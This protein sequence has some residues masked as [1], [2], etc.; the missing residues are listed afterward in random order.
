M[1]ENK[2]NQE[3]QNITEERKCKLKLINAFFR[4]RR[5]NIMVIGAS[6]GLILCLVALVVHKRELPGEIIGLISAIAGIFGACLKE[7]YTSEFSNSD[8]KRNEDNSTKTVN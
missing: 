1:T 8:K 6:L 4:N 7:A 3:K 5:M 2:N